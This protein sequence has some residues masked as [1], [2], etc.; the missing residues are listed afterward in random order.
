[1]DRFLLFE[2][3]VKYIQ[4]SNSYFGDDRINWLDA[5]VSPLYIG[6]LQTYQEANIKAGKKELVPHFYTTI[7]ERWVDFIHNKKNLK[8]I[9][10][11]ATTSSITPSKDAILFIPAEPTHTKQFIPIW[12]ILREKG[13]KYYILSNK[14]QI[15]LDICKA[16]EKA[17][18]LN[19]PINEKLINNSEID[20]LTKKVKST[21]LPESYQKRLIHLI[22]HFSA[23]ASSL[24]RE[25]EKILISWKPAVVVVGY[26]ITSEGRMSV[27]LCRKHNFPSACIMHGSISGEPLDSLHFVDRFI[28]HGVAAVDYLGKLGTPKEKLCVAG[29]PYLDE[30]NL[31]NSNPHQSISKLLNL[32]IDEKYTLIALSG[33]GHSTSKSHFFKILSSIFELAAKS[34]KDKFLFK[35]HRK[36]K[37]IHYLPFLSNHPHKNVWIIQNNENGFPT[38]FFDWLRGAKVMITGTSTVAMESMLMK[39]PVITM[40]LMDEYKKV[41]FIEEGATFHVA[42]TVTLEKVYQAIL[43]NDNVMINGTQS[44]ADNFI[45]NYFYKPDGKSSERCAQAIIDLL[46]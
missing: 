15:I 20:F 42:D 6:L 9:K 38:D 21:E 18:L 39:V 19:I 5:L 13:I 22:K 36:D 14:P 26:D 25:L 12:K 7:K 46:N 44:R 16:G 28:V 23:W 43:S 4:N 41:D 27:H 8:L 2:Y 33:P 10:K 37:K 35:L 29:A 11:V 32:N 31:K 1:M 17:I 3:L 45:K 40:D 30:V 24:E 34:P